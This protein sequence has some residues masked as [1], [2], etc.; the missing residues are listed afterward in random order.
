M[1]RSQSSASRNKGVVVT[2]KYVDFSWQPI[3][4]GY[5]VLFYINNKPR[6]FAFC[7]HQNDAE[8]IVDALQVRYP[9]G[10]TIYPPVRASISGKE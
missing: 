9:N 6:R 1:Y 3:E 7:V 10:F 8:A 2:R 4:G 5:E